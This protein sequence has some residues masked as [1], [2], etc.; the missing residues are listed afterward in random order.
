MNAAPLNDCGCCAG[1]EAATPV[2]IVN[3]GGLRA[4]AYRCGTHPTFKQSMLAALSSSRF[5]ELAGLAT[6]NDDDFTIALLDAWATT[7][8]V[9]TF[10]QERIAQESFLRTATERT[11][12]LQLGR[13]IGYELRP[14]V[15]A[16]TALAFTLET[17][18]GAPAAATI[19]VGSKVQSVPGPGE[20]PQLF[21]TIERIEARPEWNA[22]RPRQT[23]PAV[24][25]AATSRVYLQGT[26]TNL[27]KG[28]PLLFLGPEVTTGDRAWDVC[29]IAAVDA[30]PAAQRTRVELSDRP[31]HFSSAPGDTVQVFV[32]RQRAALFG[33]NAPDRRMLPDATLAKFDE[34]GTPA[35]L[36][37]GLSGSLAETVT[38]VEILLP[39]ADW[40]FR[41]SGN[42]L[43]LEAIYPAITPGSWVALSTPTRRALARVSA[44]AEVGQ[45]DYTLTGKV[46]QLSVEIIASP[47]APTVSMF[48][49]SALRGT[50]VL[51][52][53]QELKLAESPAPPTLSGPSLVVPTPSGEWRSGR[54]LAVT[55][56]RTESQT[57]FGVVVALV[58]T[59]AAGRFT[60]L[61]IAPPLPELE[62]ASV[63]VN[64]NVARATHGESV[65][66]ILGSGDGAVPFQQFALRQPPLTY[67][68]AAGP[69]GARSTLEV[70]VNDVLWHEVPTL[71]ERGA[72]ERVYVTRTNDDGV[73]TIQ[74]GDGVTGARLPTGQDNVR[75][76]YRRGIGTEAL[77]KSEQLSLLLTRPLGVKGVSNPVGAEGAADREQ[78]ADAQRNAP[79]TVMT[80]DRIVS[81]QDY[82]DF[83]RAFAGVAK[84]LATWTWDGERRG[85][86]VTVAGPAGA[87]LD[88]T[89]DFGSNLLAAIAAASVPGVPVRVQSYRKAPGLFTVKARVK[90]DPNYVPATVL[91]AARARL[92][93]QFSF[94]ARSFGEPV[95]LSEVITALQLTAGVVAV[96][97]DEFRKLEPPPPVE[98]AG[99]TGAVGLIGGATLLSSRV[100]S[101]LSAVSLAATS[102]TASRLAT[103]APSTAV[104]AGVSTA[105]SAARLASTSLI[106]STAVARP[107]LAALAV[108]PVF[109]RFAPHG[110]DPISRV[111]LHRTASGNLIVDRLLAAA[112]LPGA[113]GEVT[114]AELLVLAPLEPNQI[115]VMT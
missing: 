39:N 47:T 109:R 4:I 62:L 69:A 36:A 53:S 91:A 50:A 43:P 15:A 93:A 20:K 34:E 28:D 44:T 61:T 78:L 72:D 26:A 40:K 75:A 95:H 104:S 9:L 105:L 67:V 101:R 10:Y 11:S 112:P 23:L 1:V 19:D 96:D 92:A 27:R 32:L 77:V 55:G 60:T 12:L 79:L 42:A 83:A 65:A 3:G 89:G 16:S 114:P 49:G 48:G 107:L 29:R 13:L 97:V 88:L 8:D 58:E 81:L 110:F 51:G 111:P 17:A 54:L 21:E 73:T 99:G 102:F 2:P 56:L 86:F 94:D 84:A 80:L 57:P 63:Q 5:P 113:S 87:E 76:S 71:F 64:A 115:G 24:I 22:I 68:R 33:Y 25:D 6:R 31:A 100:A 66:E 59:V 46:T 45:H 38:G 14:G 103:A 35:T 74:F 30:E 82:E 85:V 41:L 90:V 70:R 108:S 98:P 18:P 7:A 106:R 52:D 37:S